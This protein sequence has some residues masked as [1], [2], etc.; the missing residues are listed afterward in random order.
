MIDFQERT[1]K[2]HRNLLYTVITTRPDET[3]A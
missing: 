1:K 3:I 2:T